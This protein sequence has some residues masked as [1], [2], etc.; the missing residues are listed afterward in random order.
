M[1]NRFFTANKNLSLLFYVLWF[2]LSCIQIRFTEL[3]HDEAYYWGYSTR[4]D[5]GYFDHPPMI[6][7]MIKWGYALFHNELGVRLFAAITNVLMLYITEKIVNPQN[8][9]LF[10]VL[11]SSIAFL[12]VGSI[13][14]IPDSPCCFLA[15][16]F[17]MFSKSI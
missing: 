11:V 7:V 10:Y 16:A 15:Y 5:W 14:A 4:L 2:V 12:Q 8:K 13:L 1:K 3:M 9:P 17:F 6:A